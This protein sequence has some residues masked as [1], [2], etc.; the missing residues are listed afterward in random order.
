MQNPSSEA[1]SDQTA[2]STL[3]I[4]KTLEA[5]K[6]L[7][8]QVWTQQEHLTQWWGPK[9]MNLEVAELSLE[10]G[11]MFLY[12]MQAGD[13]PKMWGK[14]VYEELSAPER[15]VYVNSFSDEEGNTIRAP[16]SQTWPLELRNILTFSE[17][18]GQT[19]LT[20]QAKPQNATPEEVQTFEASLEA[21]KQGFGGTMD[22]LALYL[23]NL[24]S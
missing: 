2:K 4:T 3:V 10:P 16:F 17:E 18:N 22:N 21:I 6:E 9:G 1:T 7:V 19:I 8:Y 13:G 11:G 12:S 23:A 15:M 14:F 5:P 24:R 20:L